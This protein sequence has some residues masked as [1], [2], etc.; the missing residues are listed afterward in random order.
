M[1]HRLPLTVAGALLLVPALRGADKPTKP[2]RP[3]AQRVQLVRQMYEKL[4]GHVLGIA[5]PVRL[6]GVG[7]SFSGGDPRVRNV[8][9]KD[10]NGKKL[11]IWLGSW[12]D[13]GKAAD[14]LN[15]SG[16]RKGR[17]PRRGP[18]ESAVYGLLLRLPKEDRE[19]EGVAEILKTLDNRF[20][21][22]MPREKK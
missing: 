15:L 3:T 19:G 21:G 22:A 2:S 4:P 7:Y 18:E 13:E 1:S 17:L 12:W 9:L 16:D 5:E 14:S 10:A 11:E 8:I 20:A 6:A